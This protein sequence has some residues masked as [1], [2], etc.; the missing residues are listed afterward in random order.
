MQNRCEISPDVWL[1]EKGL[2]LW[3][4]KKLVRI[5]LKDK[6][7]FYTPKLKSGHSM[8]LKMLCYGRHWNAKDYQYYPTRSDVDDA[9]VEPVPQVI[10]TIAQPFSEAAFPNHDPN[11]DICIL[12]HYT[13]YSSLGLHKDDSESPESLEAGHPVISFSIGAACNFSLGGKNRYDPVENIKL[14]S[15]DILVFGNSSR[16]RY[17]GITKVNCDTSAPFARFID[18]GRL[19]FTLR[20]F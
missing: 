18:F 20:K 11:W 2:D 14:T 1:F 15:G 3:Q 4:Q 7:Q 16:L 10:N 19:N 6:D 13:K 9:A 17:H 5:F 8:K 12:N